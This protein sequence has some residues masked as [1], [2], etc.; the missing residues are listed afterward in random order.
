MSYRKWIIAA[1][2]LVLALAFCASAQAEDTVQLTYTGAYETEMARSM[3]G[4]I[5]EM[6]TGEDAWYWNSDDTEK[7]VLTGLG[8]LKYDYG[9]EK[10]AMQRAAELA[11]Y[12]SHTRPNGTVCFT[13]YPSN[14]YASIG[15]NIAWGYTTT[16]S[17]FEGWAEENEPYSKQGHR[18]NMLSS[19]F[20]S[21]GIGCFRYNNRLYWAQEFSS[22]TSTDAASTPSGTVTVEVLAS[23][24]TELG[25]EGGKVG[26]ELGN[27]LPLSDIQVTATA[28]HDSYTQTVACTIPGLTWSVAN[29]DIASI[30]GNSILGLSKGNTT[31]TCSVGSLSGQA[32]VK[33]LEMLQ[34]FKISL[35]GSRVFDSSGYSYVA[36][37]IPSVSEAAD[38]RIVRS[39]LDTWSTTYD[40]IHS[41]T[42]NIGVSSSDD[43]HPVHVTFKVEV[44]DDDG[45]TI[46]SDSKNFV[47]Y[48]ATGAL[49]LP[50]TLT[51]VPEEAFC[52]LG[53]VSV[54]VP[55]GC[56]SIDRRAF[57]ECDSLYSI[58]IPGSV[59]SI[60]SDAFAGC[61]SSMI[62]IAPAGSAAQAL[63]EAEGFTFF[64]LN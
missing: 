50:S 39:G 16:Q 1:L 59:S 21:V 27:Q 3:L 34:S 12:Y 10:V 22:R 41:G 7:V 23:N 19:G 53:A 28:S 29:Q 38:F 5:N 13:A 4:L 54:V 52:N 33:V 31:L 46:G 17:M 49:Y 64:E 37:T 63:A 47:V 45:F 18:R 57:A 40:D 48:P 20:V 25:I 26:V 62:V 14:L 44:I 58:R 36:V 42:V 43:V 35:D 9:L 15:E 61:D 56:S 24:I 60:D 8:E 55:D 32:P 6:R 11:L 30:S 51:S 2:M